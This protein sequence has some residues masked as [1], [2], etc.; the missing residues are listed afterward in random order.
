MEKYSASVLYK[1]IPFPK[2]SLVM[3]GQPYRNLLQQSHRVE[4]RATA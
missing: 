4:I 3:H 1:S 2:C